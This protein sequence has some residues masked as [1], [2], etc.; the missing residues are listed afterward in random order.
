MASR[1]PVAATPLS[2]SRETTSPY[3]V[4]GSPAAACASGM[5]VAFCPA[6]WS[7]TEPMENGSST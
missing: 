3:A 2:R 7:R 5:A 4:S 6:S 1:C